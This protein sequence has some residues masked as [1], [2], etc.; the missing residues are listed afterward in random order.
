MIFKLDLKEI[1]YKY[2]RNFAG[3]RPLEAFYYLRILPKRD[4]IPL[5]ANCITNNEL[6]GFF[7]DATSDARNN[8]I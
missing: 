8:V 2:V 4:M 7:F 1:L 6:L 5:I 3:S